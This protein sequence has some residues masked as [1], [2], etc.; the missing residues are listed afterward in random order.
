[1]PWIVPVLRQLPLVH[2]LPKLLM[3][4]CWISLWMQLA[5]ATSW[6]QKVTAAMFGMHM[7]AI[8]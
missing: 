1:M 8:S 7:D 5:G 4:G 2:E 6:D 3:E